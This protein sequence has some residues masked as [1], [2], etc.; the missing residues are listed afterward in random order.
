MSRFR[1][2]A[3]SGEDGSALITD[4]PPP[5]FRRTPLVGLWLV[6]GLCSGSLLICIAA[7]KLGLGTDLAFLAMLAAGGTVSGYAMGTVLRLSGV[8][9]SICNGM[10]L[11]YAG[12]GIQQMQ[13]GKAEGINLVFLYGGCILGTSL[14]GWFATPKKGT[15]GSDRTALKDG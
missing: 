13:H 2:A 11:C 3:R 15:V 7:Q 6:L 8:G 5:G 1:R 12:L 4:A 10:L 9:N 14:S